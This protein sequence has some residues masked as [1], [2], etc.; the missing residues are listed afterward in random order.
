VVMKPQR[1]RRDFGGENEARQAWTT[2]HPEP[3]AEPKKTKVESRGISRKDD[4][5][6]NVDDNKTF[7]RGGGTTT[8]AGV[9]H[10]DAEVHNLPP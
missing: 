7:L 4:L 2:E 8:R 3:W 6:R 10:R 1:F 5:G 9:Q